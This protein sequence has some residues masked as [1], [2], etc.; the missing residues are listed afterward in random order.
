MEGGGRKRGGVDFLLTRRLHH[1][2]F[3]EERKKGESST[4]AAKGEME[5]SS[6]VF[7]SES[8]NYSIKKRRERRSSMVVAIGRQKSAREEKEKRGGGTLEMIICR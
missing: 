8:Q 7:E 2:P 1:F 4:Q 6:M 3:E 5:V